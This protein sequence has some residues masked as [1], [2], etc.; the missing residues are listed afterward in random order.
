MK[1]ENGISEF[2]LETFD[3]FNFETSSSVAKLQYFFIET[4]DAILPPRIFKYDRFV[5]G[6]HGGRLIFFGKKNII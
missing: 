5:K 2:A 1:R 6:I 4:K 3:G